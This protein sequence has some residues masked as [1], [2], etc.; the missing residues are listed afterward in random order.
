MEDINIE[1][2]ECFDK[3]NA[4]GATSLAHAQGH[5]SCFML[6]AIEFQSELI[7]SLY[8]I[9]GRG[10]AFNDPFPSFNLNVQVPL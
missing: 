6:S 3:Y 10:I 4:I 8:R 1:H 5:E 7:F 9:N 2:C